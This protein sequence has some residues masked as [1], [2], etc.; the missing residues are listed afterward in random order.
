MGRVRTAARVLSDVN[1]GFDSTNQT[2][3]A[4]LRRPTNL[5]IIPN[6]ARKEKGKAVQR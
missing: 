3:V 4:F 1:A 6:K 2:Q 5:R